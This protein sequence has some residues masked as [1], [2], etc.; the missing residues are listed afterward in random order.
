[1][2]VQEEIFKTIETIVDR[3]VAGLNLSHDEP[4]IVLGTSN[5]MYIVSIKGG[6]YTV[7]DGVNLRPRANTPVWIRIPNNDYNQAYICALK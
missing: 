6:K 3:Y 7:K 2:D 1:M 4:G 5:G